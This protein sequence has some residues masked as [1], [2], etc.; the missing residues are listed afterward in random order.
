MMWFLPFDCPVSLFCFFVLNT[1]F[2]GPLGTF[3]A[4]TLTF[5]T[6]LEEEKLDVIDEHISLGKCYPINHPLLERLYLLIL[7]EGFR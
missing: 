2:S 7:Y 1:R 3:L 4:N 5:F 6:N